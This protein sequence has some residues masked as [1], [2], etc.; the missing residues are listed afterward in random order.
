MSHCHFDQVVLGIVK[1]D[2]CYSRAL[3]TQFN[4]LVSGAA[5]AILGKVLQLLLSL[6][7]FAVIEHILVSM[8]R[9]DFGAVRASLGGFSA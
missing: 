6:I 3:I 4:H 1:L 9:R 2:R 8:A 7:T 5:W